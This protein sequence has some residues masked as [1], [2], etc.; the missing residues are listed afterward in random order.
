MKLVK[1]RDG[2]FEENSIFYGENPRINCNCGHVI[3]V[4]DRDRVRESQA[5][6]ARIISASLQETGLLRNST[7]PTA[8]LNTVVSVCSEAAQLTD[9][10]DDLSDKCPTTYTTADQQLAHQNL[11]SNN[12]FIATFSV[13]TD[14]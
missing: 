9:S 3:H 2:N 14:V 13:F 5:V 4:L 12:N 1:S 8:D 6:D 10:T 7:R 11:A